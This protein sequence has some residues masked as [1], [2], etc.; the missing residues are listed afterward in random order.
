M[1]IIRNIVW[2]HPSCTWSEWWAT[3]KLFASGGDLS[4]VGGGLKKELGQDNEKTQD[5]VLN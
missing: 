4:P 2:H 3:I 1:Y 5:D